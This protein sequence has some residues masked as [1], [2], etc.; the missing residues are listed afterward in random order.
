MLA[1]KNETFLSEV[2][3][4]NGNVTSA[5]ASA[6]DMVKNDR[7]INLRINSKMIDAI[8]LALEIGAGNNRSDFIRA[9]IAEKLQGLEIFQKILKEMKE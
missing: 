9:A 3:F 7:Q 8:D 2:S 1:L 5:T 6:R 4:T